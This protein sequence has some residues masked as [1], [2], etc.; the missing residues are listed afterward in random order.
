MLKTIG[1]LGLAAS[2]AACGT[3]KVDRAISGGALGASAGVVGSALT[4]RDL[5]SGA[6]LGGLVGA[7]AGG[8]T[9]NESINLGEPIFRSGY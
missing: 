3:S 6:L 5:A 7:A 2:L 1:I 9:T 8:L 4:G